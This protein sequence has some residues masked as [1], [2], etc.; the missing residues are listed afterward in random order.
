MDD[1][2]R[3]NIMKHR[4]KVNTKILIHQ[5]PYTIVNLIKKKKLKEK[6][7][8]MEKGGIIRKLISP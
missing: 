4:I 1:L 5:K 3:I 2:E 8:K 7:E 6:L